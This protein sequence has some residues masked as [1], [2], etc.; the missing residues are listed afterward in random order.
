MRD[1]LDDAQEF[2]NNNKATAG[3]PI[4]STLCNEVVALRVEI[5][6]LKAEKSIPPK[7]PDIQIKIKQRGSES[8]WYDLVKWGEG[9][10]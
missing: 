2:M 8:V 6:R 4:I 9:R 7:I 1:I 3:K 10:N 5:E